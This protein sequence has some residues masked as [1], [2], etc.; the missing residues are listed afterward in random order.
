MRTSI[1]PDRFTRWLSARD[2][3]D[4]AHEPHASWPCSTLSDKRVVAVFDSNGLCDFAVNGRDANDID[5]TELSAM[6]ADFMRAKLPSG[7]ICR[8]VAVDQF[9]D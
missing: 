6:V 7:H 3:Y 9:A 2:T 5:G 8:F 4:W 1:H